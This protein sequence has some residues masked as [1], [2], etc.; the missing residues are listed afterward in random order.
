MK[1]F[2][3]VV[4]WIFAVVGILT[5]I[6]MIIAI[7][8]FPQKKKV[9]IDPGTYLELS[10][11]GV[12]HDYNEYKDAFFIDENSSIGDLCRKIESAEEDSRIAGI[13]IK[14]QFYQAGWALTE[15]LRNSLIEFK[16]AGKKI[17]SYINFTSDKGYYLATVADSIFLN[18]VASAGLALAGI[19]IELKYLKG[20]LDKIGVEFTVIHQGEYKGAGETYS[21]E[22]IS[23]PMKESLTKI[24]ENIYRNYIENS[25]NSRS[26]PL[27]NYEEMMENRTEFIISGQN[28]LDYKLVDDVLLE[29]EFVR[30]TS[31]ENRVVNISDYNTKPNIISNKIAVIYAQG[32]IVMSNNSRFLNSNYRCITEKK[33]AKEIDRISKM[34]TVQG[35]VLR[36]NSGGGSALVSENI[37]NRLKELKKEKNIPIVVSMGDVAASGGYMISCAANRIFAQP[38]TITGSIGVAAMIPNWQK[39]REKAGVNTYLIKRG[40]FAGF[41]SPNFAPNSEDVN[42]MEKKM[43]EVYISFKNIVADNREMTMGEVQEIAQGKIWSGIEA[44]KIGLVDEIGGLAEA[45]QK[46]A[47]LANIPNYSTLLLPQQKTLIQMILDENTGLNIQSILPAI[48]YDDFSPASEL[49]KHKNLIKSFL[50]EPLQLILP[51]EIEIN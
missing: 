17:Y 19:G 10:L 43:K 13:I 46:A 15:E 23:K 5:I 48:F 26:I 28:A 16:Q 22:T 38:N 31:G 44:K 20:F 35:L 32:N 7:K 24:I 37:L 36:V 2:G 12:H 45:I 21:R 42:A 14:P 4:L 39:L 1:K 33:I 18:P 49:M 6:L 11:G 8:S 41:F 29:N 50:R 34:R 25:S 51:F 3:K 40:K 27:T 47:E 30:R 9:A